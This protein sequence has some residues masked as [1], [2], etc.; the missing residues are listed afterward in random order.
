MDKMNSI[1]ILLH[2]ILHL[3]NQYMFE[4]LNILSMDTHIFGITYLQNQDNTHLNM[5]MNKFHSV[6]KNSE[7]NQ[8]IFLKIH[9]YNKEIYKLNNY[10]LFDR[11]LKDKIGDNY[12]SKSNKQYIILLLNNFLVDHTWYNFQS[13]LSI[14][15]RDIHKIHKIQYF[16]LK[17]IQEGRHLHI[18]IQ[19]GKN[20]LHILNT[21]FS[22][23]M[24]CMEKH[25]F[26]KN[27]HHLKK[28]D[29]FQMSKFQ[30]IIQLEDSH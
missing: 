23:S 6:N 9:K 4:Y 3:S 7:Y 5:F 11:K 14:I 20:Y 22:I 17:Q 25:K 8:Y 13:I 2:N 24:N 12:Y 1:N 18:I 26:H 16:K 27:F 10:L 30:H 29:I 15:Y 21:Y 28:L 19:R